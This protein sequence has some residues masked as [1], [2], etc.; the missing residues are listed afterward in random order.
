MTPTPKLKLFAA[1]RE[2]PLPKTTSYGHALDKDNNIAKDHSK[3]GTSTTK[4]GNTDTQKKLEMGIYMLD[5][6]SS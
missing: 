2:L 6:L 4:Y 1:T 5:Q 3:Q